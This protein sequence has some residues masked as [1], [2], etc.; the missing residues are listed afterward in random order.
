MNA[1]AHTRAPHRGA[2]LLLR[3]CSVLDEVPED[4]REPATQRL[5]DLIGGEMAKRLVSAL[6]GSHGLRYRDV[7]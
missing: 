3:H 1:A 5:A 7:V 6:A 4:G 2:H